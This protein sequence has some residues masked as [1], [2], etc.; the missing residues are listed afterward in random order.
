MIEEMYSTL[1]FLYHVSNPSH[2]DKQ[3]PYR[4]LF[5]CNAENTTQDMSHHNGF[6]KNI[7]MICI[8]ILEI[9]TAATQY[10]YQAVGRRRMGSVGCG[11]TKP[12]KP[13][14]TMI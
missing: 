4:E 10:I 6:K 7:P 3:V 11:Q 12:R 1:V 5:M 8:R 14:T 9:Y 13:T 2:S